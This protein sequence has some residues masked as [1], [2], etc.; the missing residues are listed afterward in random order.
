MAPGIIFAS[1]SFSLALRG[2]FEVLSVYKNCVCEGLST[3]LALLAL[4]DDVLSQVLVTY[5][6][7]AVPRL[8]G[9]HFYKGKFRGCNFLLAA[10]S[11]S[12]SLQGT[13]SHSP[14]YVCEG[15]RR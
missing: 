3:P 13:H 5:L 7:S 11:R 15:C 9:I 2:A 10:G 8:K 6:A 12:R 14:I 1:P 4:P